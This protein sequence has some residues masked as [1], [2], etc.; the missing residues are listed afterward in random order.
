V[1]AKPPVGVVALVVPP[2]SEDVVLAPPTSLVVI[3]G[4]AVSLSELLGAV[5]LDSVVLLATVSV[6]L[7]DWGVVELVFVAVTLVVVVAVVGDPNACQVVEVSKIIAVV[8]VPA[9]S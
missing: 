3:D 4:V 7:V 5:E 1:L 9:T 6:T 8:N 2:S